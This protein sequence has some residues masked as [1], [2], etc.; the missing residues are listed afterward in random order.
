MKQTKSKPIPHPA[1]VAVN[2]KQVM[3]IL[4]VAT[5]PTLSG[6]G[7]LT[8]HIGSNTEADIC[9][10]VTA[11]SGGGFFSIEWVSLKAIQ[12]T[13]EQAAQPLTSYALR[14]LFKGKS[15]NNPAF[16]MAALKHEGLVVSHPEKQRCYDRVNLAS[17]VAEMGKLQAS[18]V[19]ITVEAKT[20]QIPSFT[21]PAS[22]KNPEPAEAE[23]P[24][25]VADA[26]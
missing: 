13:L 10:L 7:E 4:K 26:N 17:F 12:A 1:A 11:N 24:L 23:S 22:I 15:A 5:C 14:H 2:T 21:K 9:F 8:Y 25:I 20:E 19:N 18:N 6:K 16:L 3:R